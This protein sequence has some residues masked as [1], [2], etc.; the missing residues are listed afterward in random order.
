[1]D[2]SC[3]RL[4]F[5]PGPAPPSRPPRLP[6]LCILFPE[7]APLSVEGETPVAVFSQQR[8]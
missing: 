3:N 1:M 4:L 5:L 7:S 6:A 2:H 8:L